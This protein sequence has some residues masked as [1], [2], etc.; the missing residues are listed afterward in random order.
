MLYQSIILNSEKITSQELMNKLSLPEISAVDIWENNQDEQSSISIQT[1]HN[2]NSWLALM[3][4]SS[5]I[6][7]AIIWQAEKLTTEAQNAL[8]KNLE[9]PPKASQIVLATQEPLKLLPTILS[10]CRLETLSGSKFKAESQKLLEAS[11][12]EWANSDYLKKL[13]LIQSWLKDHKREWF[14]KLTVALLESELAGFKESNIQQEKLDK[15]RDRLLLLK[16][17]YSGLEHNANLQPA[18]ETL[19]LSW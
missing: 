2:L 13:N 5:A 12:S 8:L 15:I 6:K 16:Q 14:I 11:V 10:R 18:L 19:A 4:H 3:P 7:L 17:I 9:E 1:I